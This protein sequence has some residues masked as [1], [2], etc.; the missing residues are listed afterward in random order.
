MDLKA[1][2]NQLRE[3]LEAAA[4]TGS[5][6]EAKQV[7]ELAQAYGRDA[8]HFLEQGKREDAVEAFGISWAYL[9]ALLHMGLL[10]VPEQFLDWFTVE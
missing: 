1:Q 6:P 8:R 3:V 9:D 10:T 7:F 2:L 4:L 5:G